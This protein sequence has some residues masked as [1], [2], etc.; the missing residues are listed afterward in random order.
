MIFFQQSKNM[1]LEFRGRF[2]MT[3][4]YERFFGALTISSH[5]R[6]SLYRVTTTLY[7]AR[8]HIYSFVKPFFNLY[9]FSVLENI[10]PVFPFKPSFSTYSRYQSPIPLIIYHTFHKKS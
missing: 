1:S 9:C 10:K 7:T 8:F 4:G 6:M 5:T 2:F 3:H